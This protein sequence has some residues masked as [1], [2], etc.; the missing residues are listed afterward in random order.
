[1]I[2]VNRRIYFYRLFLK[3]DEKEVKPNSIFS[4]INSLPFTDEGRYLPLGDGN[5]RSMYVRNTDLPLKAII[6][7]KR[8][9]GLPSMDLNG[10][11]SPL[12][13]PKKAGL[14]EPMHF[15]IFPKNV[16]GFEYNFYGPR[17]NSLSTYIPNK[18]PDLVDKVEL[19][20]LLRTN[21]T[22]LLSKMGEIKMFQLAVHRNMGE[23]LKIIGD[24]VF[25]AFESL[26]KSDYSEVIEIVL[27]SERYSRKGIKLPFK[28]R[29]ANFLAKAKDNVD[30]ARIRA[31]NLDNENKI[32]PFDL[33][34][35]F[36]ISN[37][38]IELIDED[39]RSVDSESMFSN[40][41]DAY[42]E[43][44]PDINKIIDEVS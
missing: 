23:H 32:E 24:N 28:E 37:R 42:Q 13:I 39:H 15:M 33:L 6:G 26:K 10:D 41:S 38:K 1:M 16:I 9:T 34:E 2:S 3:K 8:L 40:I 22:E 43:L 30:V 19:I 7:N 21:I 17:I 5:S 25:D 36:M 4:Y 11:I 12:P 27:R 20:P 14:Y 18:A 44:R 29:L 31:E 35:Q